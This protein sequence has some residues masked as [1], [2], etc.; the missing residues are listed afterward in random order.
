MVSIQENYWEN[1]FIQPTINSIVYWNFQI[2]RL[3]CTCRFYFCRLLF[4]SYWI[5]IISFTASLSSVSTPFGCILSGYM[6]DALGR[7][8]TII[9]TLMPMILGWFLISAAN[10][11]PLIYIGRLLV[12]LGAGM[13]G[14]PARVY[15]GE[16][17][18]PH[19]RGMLAAVAS[20]G[21]SLGEI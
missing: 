5:I 17:T 8:R 6:L 1:V 19:L 9:L 2:C 21:V 14:S 4:F 12:G 13:V 16:V 7:K 10:N 11:V 3:T 15:T 18:Q 20:V